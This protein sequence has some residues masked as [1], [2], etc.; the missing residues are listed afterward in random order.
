MLDDFQCLTTTATFDCESP[1]RIKVSIP[2]TFVIREKYY[3]LKEMC[4]FLTVVLQMYLGYSADTPNTIIFSIR[5]NFKKVIAV[6][7]VI[8]I[9]VL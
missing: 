3:C 9:N 7:K 8:H 4:K 1:G 2:N 5:Y 6:I